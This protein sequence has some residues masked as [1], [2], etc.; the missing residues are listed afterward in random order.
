[1]WVYPLFHFGDIVSHI[2]GAYRRRNQTFY[3][4]LFI[5]RIR[6]ELIVKGINQQGFCYFKKKR[7]YF[8][9]RQRNLS[10][11]VVGKVIGAKVRDKTFFLAKV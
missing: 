11:E 7:R 2:G 3:P 6:N 10:G 9:I 8:N 4:P 5:I 1:M